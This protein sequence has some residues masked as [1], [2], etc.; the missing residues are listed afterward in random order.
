MK[1]SHKP[2]RKCHGCGLN[3][4]ERCGVYDVPREMWRHRSCKGYENEAMLRE[5]EAELARRAQTDSRELRREV[6]KRRA[7]EPHYQGMLPYANR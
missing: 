2:V 6:A 3:L 7:S 5:Y 4:G 1:H